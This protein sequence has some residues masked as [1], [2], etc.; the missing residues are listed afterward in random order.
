MTMTDKRFKEVQDSII[1]K[2]YE[3]ETKEDAL[4][5][6]TE[7]FDVIDMCMALEHMTTEM[8]KEISTIVY[9]IKNEIEESF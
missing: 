5:M 7:S 2:L 8:Y 1:S 3:Q 4:N 9:R 6:V